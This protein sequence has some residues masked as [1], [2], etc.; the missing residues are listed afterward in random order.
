ML[1]AIRTYLEKV[2][3]IVTNK[4]FDTYSLKTST[5]STNI[6]VNA[7]DQQCYNINIAAARAITLSDGPV[8]RF[9]TCVFVLTG[10]TVVPTFPGSKIKWSRG[11]PLELGSTKTIVTALWDG[12]EWI[13]S[14]VSNY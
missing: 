1:L 9:I 2:H 3:E 13:L 14:A 6:T 12:T 8:G 11:E 5:V 7:V 10:G 4:G